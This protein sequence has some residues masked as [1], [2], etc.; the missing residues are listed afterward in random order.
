MRRFQ[1]KP[2]VDFITKTTVS[3]NISPLKNIKAA[4]ADIIS[5]E[6]FISFVMREFVT[7]AR[8]EFKNLSE[9]E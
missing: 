9:S 8:S 6:P 1:N 2:P 5:Q 3:I 4:S 7:G